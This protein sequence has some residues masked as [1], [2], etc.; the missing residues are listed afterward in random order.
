MAGKGTD[1]EPVSAVLAS[2]SGNFQ[3]I[4]RSFDRL[5]P[6][7][8]RFISSCQQVGVRLPVPDNRERKMTEQGTHARQMAG[9]RTASTLWWRTGVEL[10]P[11]CRDLASGQWDCLWQL[12]DSRPDFWASHGH[13][14]D[15]RDGVRGHGD[16]PRAAARDCW[17]LQNRDRDVEVIGAGRMGKHVPVR[18]GP[19]EQSYAPFRAT[20]GE[21]VASRAAPN[22]ICTLRQS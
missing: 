19:A 10:I 7:R 6:N 15:L 2:G 8:G 18:V 4:S 3:P 21:A 13:L 12:R 1:V 11:A 5:E 17:A 9:L 14:L 16:I 20:C 22:S